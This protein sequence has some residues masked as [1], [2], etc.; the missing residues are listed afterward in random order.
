MALI[1]C[2]EC[3]KQ[4]SDT[5]PACPGCGAPKKKLTIREQEAADGLSPAEKAR[6]AKNRAEWGL[7]DI[8]VN[9]DDSVASMQ[10]ALKQLAGPQCPLCGG[11]MEKITGIEGLFRGGIAGVA[12]KLRCRKCGHLA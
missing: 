6:R 3:G 8:D 5:A 2:H 11:S 10:S 1:N 4:I 9:I 12:K 7:T